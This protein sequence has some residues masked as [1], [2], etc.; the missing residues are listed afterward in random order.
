MPD[1]NYKNGYEIFKNKYII[2]AGYPKFESLLYERSISS[3]KITDINNCEFE[4]SLD[5]SKGSSGSP[6][7][8]KDG[9]NVIGIH[10]Q[11]DKYKPINYGT[12]LGIVLDKLV[13]DNIN[14]DKKKSAQKQKEL[15]KKNEIICKLK[16]ENIN[17]EILL[18]NHG[19]RKCKCLC[20]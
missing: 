6:I 10:K 11:G 4:H 20:Q 17:N 1:L 15:I 12:F 2:L 19:N 8:S 9:L 5:T 7:C 18:F 13:N 14:D 16:I 3:G